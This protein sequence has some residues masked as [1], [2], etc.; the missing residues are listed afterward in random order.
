MAN[1]PTYDELVKRVLQLENEAILL[2]RAEETLRAQETFFD[3]VIDQSPYATW[4]SDAEGTLER[5]NP[6]L[7]K[8]LNLTDEQLVGKYNVL[9]DPLVE[10]QGLIP[11]IRTVYEEGK[12]INFFCE[13]DG[14]D[15][16]TLDLKGSNSVCIEATMFP[17]FNAE[18]ELTHA[19]VT[20]IDISDRS[21]SEAALR[22]SEEKY[23]RIFENSVVG[24][25]QSTPEGRFI[26]VNR[27]FAKMLRY[28]SPEDLVSSISDI[29]AQYYVNPE[30]RSQYQRLLRQTGKVDAFEFKARCKDGTEIWVSNSTR[31]YFDDDGNVVHYEGV[32]SDITERKH[33]EAAL[34]E[35][36]VALTRPL[37][38]TAESVS[39]EHLFNIDQIQRLQDEFADATGVASI[40]TRTDGTPITR[41]SNFC[42]L[43]IDIIRKTET[44]L[45]NC[46]RSDAEIGRF[47]SEGPIIQ[48]CMSGGLWDAGA[49]ITIGGKHIAN[50][51]I[52][53]VRDRT[54]TEEKMR[55]YAKEIGAD[56]EAVVEAFR[57]VPAMSRN[58]FRQVAQA[59]FTLARQLSTSAYQNVQQARFI[60]DLKRSEEEQKNLQSRLVQAQKMEAVG[61]LAGGV[62]H[63]FNNMLSII[64]GHTEMIL[65]EVDS[66]DPH[67]A[68]LKE[69]RRAA[70]RSTDLT[71][72]LLA[73][74]RKQTIA[75]KVLD[76]NGTVEG[77]LKMLKR[78]I[79]ENIDLAWE[80]TSDLWPI[81]MDPSQVDQVLANL[82]VNAR[83]SIEEVGRLT[84][85]T[86]NVSFDEDYCRDH[87]GFQPGDYSMIA[88]S[89]NGCGMDRETLNNL[90]EPFFTTKGV[91]EGTG[92]GLATVYG[93][94]KQNSG[95]INVYSEPGKGTT[96]KIYLPRH[97]TD[98]QQVSQIEAINEAATGY[99][100][101]LVVEDEQAIL[102]MTKMMLERL[103]Y[104]VLAASSPDEAIDLCTSGSHEIHMLMTDVVMPGMSGRDLASELL[105]SYP[106]LRC[107][108]MSGYTANVI[109]HHGVL[110]EGVK[111]IN[112]PFTKLDLAA[113]IRKVLDG[114]KE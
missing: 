99:E 112:K 26:S 51:L 59:L 97:G 74:A 27:A 22:E 21:R 82:C 5:A 77:M 8:F 24:F 38:D 46:F 36:I 108:F 61:R 106:N 30:D 49:G 84:I 17:I 87:A 53:Q 79:G 3:R 42:R 7:K 103:G 4:I 28:D 50:W 11:L 83:D 98:A 71:R 94:V 39:F 41:P 13:W 67:V 1:A 20:W 2:K 9:K 32:I 72:Q 62:A 80:P 113:K 47:H 44:G 92:L 64:L 45:L 96:F 33:A 16:P 91:G 75:P 104:T 57:E 58:R 102:R 70:R 88:V 54:Q 60:S 100:T 18:G 37:E 19:V 101:I 63:D 69:I 107:L 35:R 114:D 52:G 55:E 105:R 31:A 10:R 109:A 78:L 65:D 40:I 68:N 43:C 48:P 73:F 95:F 86:G 23:R 93:I 66:T 14:N 34:E 111:F 25:F 110:D 29:A 89:D 76:L 90:F 81:K 6:A 56:E 85:E 12:T 15:I